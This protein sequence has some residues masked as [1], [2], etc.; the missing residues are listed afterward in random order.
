MIYILIHIHIC[1]WIS[2]EWF[3]HEDLVPILTD[4]VLLYKTWGI[5][6]SSPSGFA[7][8]FPSKIVRWGGF[9]WERVIS[10]MC[11]FWYM[12]AKWYFEW[13][14]GYG[15]NS[16]SLALLFC[17]FLSLP[18]WAIKALRIYL[19]NLWTIPL[20]PHFSSSEKSPFSTMP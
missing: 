9:L 11:M 8:V 15:T 20:N 10:V 3:N 19:L 18:C 14:Q 4:L 17:F 2:W 5:W 7:W 1:K 6:N 13:S 12:E 16:F